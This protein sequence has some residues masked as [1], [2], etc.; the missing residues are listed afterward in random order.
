MRTMDIDVAVIGA[1]PAGLAAAVKAREQG[2]KNL[3]V[4]EREDR[5]GGILKQCI[6][7]GFGLEKFQEELTGPEYAAKYVSMAEKLGI[8]VELGATV[9]ELNDRRELQVVSGSGGVKT[10]RCKAVILAM[11]CRERP[12]GALDLPGS[13]PAGIFTAG[14]AQKLINIEGYMPGREIV[15]LGSGDIG[16]IMARR[17]TLEGARVKAVLEILPYTSGL[18]RNEV[19]CLHDFGIP[20]LLSHTVSDIHGTERVEGVTVSKV[21]ERWNYAPGSATDISCDTLL[22]SVGLIPEN[23]LSRNAGVKIDPKTGGPVVGELMETSLPGIFSCGNVL[24]VNDLVDNVS[25]EGEIAALGAVERVREP[26]AAGAGGISLEGDSAIGQITPHFVS[27]LRDV[28]VSLRVR[29]PMGRV[30]IHIGDIHRKSFAYARPGEMIQ[31]KVPK[32]AF[33]EMNGRTSLMVRCEER[34]D[35]E[36]KG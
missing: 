19:Q 29:K 17:L 33:Q 27:G 2:I 32:K 28:T 1:G 3:V 30:R 16:M 24:H 15:V 26:D 10:Y 6:H 25:T 36:R 23:E 14:H 5:A 9:L 34:E 18:I 22:L 31:I 13:R 12:R 7:N 8:D 11:G 21:D 20:L 4:L 35:A